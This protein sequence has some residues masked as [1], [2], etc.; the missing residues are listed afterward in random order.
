MSST[1][2]HPAAALPEAE[3]LEYLRL[4]ASMAIADGRTAGAEMSK[5]VRLGETL[6]LPAAVTQPL[7][8]AVREGHLDV[9]APTEGAR[10]FKA[11]NQIGWHLMIDSIVIAFSD[12]ELASKESQRIAQLARLLEVT[13]GEVARM[14]GLVEQILWKREADQA[15]LAR[16]LGAAVGAPD[17]GVRM[18]G[19]IK[20][21]AGTRTRPPGA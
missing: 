14:A 19:V 3:R 16:E 10:W 6:R 20:L 2:E 13:P 17:D 4:V 11:P 12:G 15:A 21:V 7:M 1:A 5:L 18:I 8:N 9:E